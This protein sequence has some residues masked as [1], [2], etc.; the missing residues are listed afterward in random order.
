MGDKELLSAGGLNISHLNVASILGAHK[1]EMLKKQV[2]ESHFDIFCASETWL[3]T[4]IPDRLVDIKGYNLT[5]LDRN[6]R[7]RLTD[8]TVKKGGGLIC[9]VKEGLVMNESRYERLNR[10]SRDL[11]MQWVSL[12]MLHMRRIVVINVYRPPQGDYKVACKA[13]HDSIREA[14]LKDNAEIFLLG[15]FNINFRDK[16]SPQTKE[17]LSTTSFWGL[18]PLIEGITRIGTREGVLHETSIDNIFSNSDAVV[19]SGVVD[20]NF[21]DHL[22]IAAKRK[23]VKAAHK[24]VEFEGRSYRNYVR[25]E[26]QEI[27]I[28][29]DWEGFYNA[30]DPSICWEILVEHILS[31]LNTAC[32]KKKFKIKEI[33]EPWVSNEL[34]EEIKDKDRVLREAKRTGKVE[35]WDTAKRERNRVGRLV[36]QA[37]SEFLKEQQEELADDPKK[38]WR[39]IKSIVPGKKTKQCRISLSTTNNEGL[40]VSLD[41]EEIAGFI[42]DYFSKIGPKLAEQHKLP[43]RFYGEKCEAQC[44][45]FATYFGQVLKLSKDINVSKSSGFAD[46]STKIF[47]DAFIVLVPQ[48]VYMFN[49]S[50]DKCLFP[51]S[52][53]KATIIPLYKGGVKTEVTN[54]RPVSLLPLPGKLLEKIA[55]AHLSHFFELNDILTDKQGGFRKGFSTASSI[56][57]LTD[58]LLSS[59]NEG[60]ISM[61]TFIDL[62]KAFDT[63]DHSILLKK[64]K[65]YGVTGKNLE[66][67]TNYLL[68]RK[69]R[70][71]ANGKLSTENGITC[72]VPQGS[73]IG[74]LFFILYVNDIQFAVGGASTQLYADDTVIYVKGRNKEE[75]VAKLQPA[76]DEFA[77]WCK[78]NKLTLNA[79]KTKLMI[80]GTRYRIKRA[81][82]AM[83][84]IGKA[85][86]QIVP[87]YKYLGFNLDSTLS[88]SNH[89]STV[90]SMVAYKANLLAKIR[91]FLT[92]EVA[93]KIYK[94][95]ILPYFDYGDVIY[96]QGNQEGLDKLQ[97]LQNRCLK[98]CKGYNVR[99]DTG[100]LHSVTK[101]PRLQMRRNAHINNFMY[102]RLKVPALLDA[103]EIRTRAHDAPLF[104]VKV[105]KVE[106]YKRSIEYAGSLHWNS[107]SSDIRNIRVLEVFK[108]K[109]KATMLNGL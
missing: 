31:Y 25:E 94:S 22:V 46:I 82:N 63:V 34:I 47:K 50:F 30:R 52:W 95:M 20:W 103:R 90:S 18:K 104:K 29:K 102:G 41:D 89:I 79:A 56:A 100:V 107:L 96:N 87:S 43:W 45:P 35:D 14:D 72:G 10:S 106:A 71:L 55:H 6:W 83:V 77:M 85:P 9:Y 42:N 105:P 80:F 8:P 33:R 48:L 84:K 3:T 51:D 11:E 73:V 13:L 66:W 37:K 98:I 4:S 74:P 92:D 86:L 67:C 26:F 75:A 27:M 2:E 38:F 7:E 40:E 93:L 101:V 76:L 88:F 39:L 99:F 91:K 61:A 32:P 24:K 58:S 57:D 15:D 1:F 97:R 23:R 108:A 21:S 59:V 44:P 28:N 19:K 70:T 60:M 16:K 49:L 5:R 65:C 17:M 109:Q 53:K 68:N 36:E 62:R 78:A 64:L 81:K 69:Q 54:Y 12:E